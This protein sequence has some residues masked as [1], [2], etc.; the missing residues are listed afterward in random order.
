MTRRWIW[1]AG[2]VI[3]AH[4]AAFVAVGSLP[5]TPFK[6]GVIGIC[7][8]GAVCGQLLVIGHFDR[9]ASRQG[10]DA[11]PQP[12]PDDGARLAFA[13]G[14]LHEIRQPLFVITL[15][16]RNALAQVGPDHAGEKV[17]QAALVR[18]AAQADKATAIA[19]G[20]LDLVRSRPRP[21]ERV[22]IAGAIEACLADWQTTGAAAGIETSLAPEAAARPGLDAMIDPVGFNQII[23]N[24]LQ[25][26]AES[27]AQRRKTG[28][29]GVGRI[30]IELAREA[31]CIVC[32]ISDNGAGLDAATRERAFDPFY[33]TK[34]ERPGGLGLFLSKEILVRAGGAIGLDPLPSGGA[35]VTLRLPAA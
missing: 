19:D 32:H 21:A 30:D 6:L 13:L 29:T 11:P 26:A 3:A 12:E 8:A 34:P 2:P 10:R 20:M 5:L 7:A 16:A 35:R 31:N 23:A 28:W 33:S 27:I 9:V 15:A 18:I 14:V 1:L 17:L 25:N 22:A 24:T 4:A